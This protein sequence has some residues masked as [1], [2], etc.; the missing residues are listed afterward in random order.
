MESISVVLVQPKNPGNI[1][2]IARAMLNCGV[3][4]LRLV[5]PQ[6]DPLSD[7]AI[8]RAREAKWVI[9]QAQIHMS[10]DRAVA[11][12]SRAWGTSRRARNLE[13]I[14][15]RQAAEKWQSDGK[16]TA[17][18]FGPEDRG[19][20]N[21]ELEPCDGLI[22]IP[23]SEAFPSL[24]LS[25]AVMITLYEAYAAHLASS[26]APST[27]KEIATSGQREGFYGHLEEALT[28]IGFLEHHNPVHIM[29]D[30]RNLF[31]RADL[32]EREVTI[33]RGICRQILNRTAQ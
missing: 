21:D 10:V 7:E 12:R 28:K 25:H 1:G 19:L 20:S 27:P 13:V 4:D 30:L 11:D 32:T 3:K 23:T 14:S 2:A 33:L 31:S 26:K 15:V 29:R 16:S 22:S 8:C 24:N 5:L 9:E 18:V 17:Y 6:C